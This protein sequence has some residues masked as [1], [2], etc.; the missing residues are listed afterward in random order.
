MYVP[1]DADDFAR[2]NAVSRKT[3]NQ[4]PAQRIL[5]RKIEFRKCLADQRYRWRGREIRFIEQTATKQWNSHH[6]EIV[7]AGWDV[8]SG[9]GRSRLPWWIADNLKGE[10]DTAIHHGQ[11]TRDG[12]ILHAGLGRK[13]NHCQSN[14][15]NSQASAGATRTCRL[16]C[17][18][19]FDEF[20]LGIRASCGKHGG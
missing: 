15:R 5:V 6:G 1:N 13:K 3:E 4:M 18:S 14:F 16:P 8:I 2:D 19:A 7:R 20:L 9:V 17:A 11:R 10:G 12:R